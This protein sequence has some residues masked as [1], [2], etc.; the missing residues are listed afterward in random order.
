MSKA[1]EKAVHDAIAAHVADESGGTEWLTEYVVCASAIAT[2]RNDGTNYYRL[3]P[4]NQP[5]HHS[6]GLWHR[7]LQMQEIDGDD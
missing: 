1:T 5:Y 6:L 4:E 7:G 2:E 3:L